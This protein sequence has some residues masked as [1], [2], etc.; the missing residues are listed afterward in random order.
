[1]SSSGDVHTCK[2]RKTSKSQ[3]GNLSK[4]VVSQPDAE[5]D[6]REQVNEK[7]W[8]KWWCVASLMCAKHFK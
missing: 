7:K 5:P 1:M 2:L 3:Q 6:S 8:F 4:L